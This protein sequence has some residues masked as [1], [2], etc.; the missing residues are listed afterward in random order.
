MIDIQKIAEQA[1]DN[2]DSTQ[3]RDKDFLARFAALYREALVAELIAGSEEPVAW[4]M[5]HISHP[6]IAGVYSVT[7]LE[8]EAIEWASQYAHGYA[9][10]TPL[11]SQDQLAGAVLRERERCAKIADEAAKYNRHISVEIAVAIRS[12]E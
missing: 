11:L 10:V 4:R 6:N 12:G 5:H 2:W 8:H 3:Q 7:T 1:G 9:K